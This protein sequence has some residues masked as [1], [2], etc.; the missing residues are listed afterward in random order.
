MIPPKVYLEIG[1]GA[2]VGA[3]WM[4]EPQIENGNWLLLMKLIATNF[5]GLLM[6]QLL[7]T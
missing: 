7:C 1:V 2:H 3:H 5:K 6:Q 4:V